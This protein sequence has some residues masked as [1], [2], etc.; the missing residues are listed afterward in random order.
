MRSDS[1][2][3]W[4]LVF[5]G[6]NTG[7]A[8]LQY[9]GDNLTHNSYFLKTTDRG[10]T[11]TEHPFVPNYHEQGIGFID[12]NVGWIGGDYNMPNY[13]TTDGGA[14]WTP[15]PGFGVITPPFHEYPAGFRPGFAINRFRRFG[16]SLLY[17]TGKTVYK[18]NIHETSL[19]DEKA[20]E[21]NLNLKNYPNP[22]RDKTMISYSLPEASGN[23]ILDVWNIRGVKVFERNIGAKGRGN[24]VYSFT[25]LLPP[26]VFYYSVRTD[27][28]NSTMSMIVER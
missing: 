13:K 21:A 10:R 25:E 20:L 18:M 27:T 16:D 28:Y 17:A 14:T 26:G 1:E 12:D 6:G 22:F 15:D 19:P 4:K 23:V 2:I 3:I 7:Y 24:H 9:D 11:W 8:A 5:P